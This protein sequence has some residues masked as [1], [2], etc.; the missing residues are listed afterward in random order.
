MYKWI[1]DIINQ[2]VIVK[3]VG[4]FYVLFAPLYNYLHLQIMIIILFA[5]RFCVYVH[6]YIYV[7]AFKLPRI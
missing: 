6:G 3:C 4:A 7:H 5:I 2:T 1:T